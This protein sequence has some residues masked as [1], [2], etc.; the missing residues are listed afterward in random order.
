MIVH[1]FRETFGIDDSV[2]LENLKRN[3]LLDK[4][5]EKRMNYLHLKGII[6]H[7]SSIAVDMVIHYK[8]GTTDTMRGVSGNEK[9][10]DV[11]KKLSREPDYIDFV[12]GKEPIESPTVE[13]AK[14]MRVVTPCPFY[15][16]S[17]WNSQLDATWIDMSKNISWTLQDI[18]RIIDGKYRNFVGY[19]VFG[20]R[21]SSQRSNLVCALGAEEMCVMVYLCRMSI[22]E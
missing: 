14:E 11:I 15:L 1:Y 10:M 22:C 12:D 6:F 8:D 13:S 20:W 16:S 2:H 4:E 7:V 19:T 21:I 3:D 17:A 5:L 18:I 9:Y